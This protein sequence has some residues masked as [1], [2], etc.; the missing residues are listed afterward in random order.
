MNCPHCSQTLEDGAAFCTRCG[1]KITTEKKPTEETSIPLYNGKKIHC[2]HCRSGALKS[3]AEASGKSLMNLNGSGKSRIFIT[4][5][6]CGTKFREPNNLIA[7][8]KPKAI[9]LIVQSVLSVIIWLFLFNSDYYTRL[10]K[11]A[12][13]NSDAKTMIAVMIVLFVADLGYIVYQTAKIV[14]IQRERIFLDANCTK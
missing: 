5:Q 14:L 3:H 1:K 2:P 11:L 7:E 13:Y 12:K 9:S 6:S 8:F 4:C 10:A